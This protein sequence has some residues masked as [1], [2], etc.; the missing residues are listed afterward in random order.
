MAVAPVRHTRRSPCLRR[1]SRL[2]T[3]VRTPLDVFNVP[4]RLVVPLFQRPYV[5]NETEQWEPL[6]SDVRRITE[7]HMSARGSRAAHFLGAIVLQRMETAYGALQVWQIIDGQ[8]RLTTLQLLL[9]SAASIFAA[10]GASHLAARLE[11]LTHNAAAYVS[12]GSPLKLQHTNRDAAAFSEVMLAEAPVD[13]DMLEFPASLPARC[14]AYFAGRITAWLEEA[15]AEQLPIRMETLANALTQALQLVVIQLRAEEDSQEIFETLNARGTPLTAADLVKNLVFQKLDSE[16]V[17]TERAYREVW[18]FESAFWE[19]EVSVGRFSMTRS[20]AF[21]NQWLISRLGEEIG[22]RHTFARFKHFVE[23]EAGIPMSALL[24]QIAGQAG[25][26]QTW[27]ERAAD[28]DRLLTSIELDIY[29]TDSLDTTVLRPVLLW[30]TAPGTSFSDR[31]VDGVVAALESWLIRRMILRRPSSDHGRVVADLIRSN[32]DASDSELVERVVGHLRRLD[33]ESTYWPGDEEI[34]AVLIDEAA[35]R[36]YSRSRLRILLEAVE[37]SYRGFTSGKPSR[38]GSRVSRRSLPIEHLLPRTWKTTWPVATVE[39]EVARDAHVHRLG[40]LTLI[41]SSLNSSVSNGPW[42]GETGKR[43]K[44]ADHDVHLMNRRVRDSSR[45]G[46]DEARIRARTAEMIEAILATWPAP[47]EHRGEILDRAT[48]ARSEATLRDLTVA[49]LLPSGSVLRARTTETVVEAIVQ[50]NGDLLLDGRT[51]DT[52][53]G[54]G[55][56]LLGRSVNGW[57]FWRFTDGR[58]LSDV[59]AEYESRRVGGARPADG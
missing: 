31:T 30:L 15:A 41:T 55:K 43:A 58:G 5:W 37:D 39:E 4:Q 44:L 46:W 22:P 9:D 57:S 11:T 18:P 21:L 1:R 23:H 29:R 25:R 38:T 53:S 47:D 19:K 20:S 52:P 51:F 27:V 16:G 2:E 24:E 10:R 45:D 35:Y 50:E 17:D 28:P 36:R 56:H 14:H 26:Y 59:R 13:Y 32:R 34:R 54:A 7:V 8:Q 12:E 48:R 33:A 42:L 49:G 3:Y 40:N 6:W